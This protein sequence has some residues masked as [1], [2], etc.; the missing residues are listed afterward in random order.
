MGGLKLSFAFFCDLV[1]G[2]PII[3]GVSTSE[4]DTEDREKTKIR[5]QG[6]GR[7]MPCGEVFSEAREHIGVQ[8]R[9]RGILAHSLSREHRRKI[10]DFS[11]L[12]VGTEKGMSAK[13][14]PVGKR[15]SE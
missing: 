12:Q 13:D 15:G 5:K 14:N 11:N 6:D 7:I 3:S 10:N 9:E 2:T 4:D 8:L 1:G